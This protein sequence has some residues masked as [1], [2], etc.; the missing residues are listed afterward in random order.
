MSKMGNLVMA[1]QEE[2]GIVM[3]PAFSFHPSELGMSRYE[4]AAK[5]LSRQGFYCSAGDC[6]QVWDDYIK[7]E[8]CEL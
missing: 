3:D 1:I 5:E 6:E 4:I 7:H 8:Y 2:V